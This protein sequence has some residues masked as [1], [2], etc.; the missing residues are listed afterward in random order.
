MLKLLRELSPR[1]GV[2]LHPPPARFA[3]AMAGGVYMPLI[4]TPCNNMPGYSMYAA[5]H[6]TPAVVIDKFDGNIL[7]FFEFNRILKVC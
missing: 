3:P 4:V 1:D 7:R 6:M 5:Q 2:K